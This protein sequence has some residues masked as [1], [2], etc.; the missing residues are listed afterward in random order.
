M[1]EKEETMSKGSI[2]IPAWACDV[3][4]E[5]RVDK[6]YVRLATALDGEHFATIHQIMLALGARWDRTDSHFVFPQKAD[7]ERTLRDALRSA[8]AG[9]PPAP[10]NPPDR[11]PTPPELAHEM[12]Q[13]AARR[14]VDQD[15]QEVKQLYGISLLDVGAGRG[16]LSSNALAHGCK[17]YAVESDDAC[18]DYLAERLP[19]LS[20]LWH[21]E[22]AQW[23]AD[24]KPHTETLPRLGFEAIV[25]HPSPYDL[26]D[27]V[28]TRAIWPFVKPGG[29]LVTMI[30]AGSWASS[31]IRGQNFRAWCDLISADV[32]EIAPI[33]YADYGEVNTSYMFV[34]VK[35]PE[36]APA[37]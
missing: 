11:L 19:G 29:R 21:M 6:R 31:H 10:D 16:H 35:P 27:I 17:V 8:A 34:A 12:L 7:V 25:S 30:S 2:H 13:M 24:M 18:V 23:I 15:W 36:E 33:L 37:A 5:A 28:V 1:S 4:G 22:T 20:H 14:A 32:I 26:Q 3:L 9:P